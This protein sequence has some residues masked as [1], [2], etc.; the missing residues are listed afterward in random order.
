MNIKEKCLKKKHFHHHHQKTGGVLGGGGVK[1]SGGG[2]G[3]RAQV[4]DIH[5]VPGFRDKMTS[6]HVG[7]SGPKSR[8]A[9][10][11]TNKFYLY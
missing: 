8:Q 7:S 1:G 11:G 6:R 3:G 5:Q 4:R 10:Q 9:L 2:G